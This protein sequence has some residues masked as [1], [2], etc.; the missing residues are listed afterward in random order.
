MRNASPSAIFLAMTLMLSS[1]VAAGDVGV[2][3]NAFAQ[4]QTAQLAGEMSRAAQLYELADSAAP[5]PEALRAALRARRASG[6]LDLA[7]T[8]AEALLERYPRDEQSAALA[9]E[10]LAESAPRLGRVVASCRPDP[11]QL[12]LGAAA[13]STQARARHVLFVAPGRHAFKA[14]FDTGTTGDKV[15]QAGAGSSSELEFAAPK[16]EAKSQPARATRGPAAS[17]PLPTAKQAGL[18]PAW[19]FAAGGVTLAL[20]ALTIWSGADTLEE[21]D[22][23]ERNPTLEGY[24]DGQALERRTNLLLVATS[25]GALATTS[26]GVFFTDWKGGSVERTAAGGRFRRV[27]IVPDLR[28]ARATAEWSF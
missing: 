28:G 2:A 27:A 1:S 14:A 11:C 22:A 4:A 8:H 24:N 26:L 17:P 18:A 5:S 25:I 15:V 16:P 21:H 12:L 6:R 19:F 10:T 13:V 9:R 3:A 23:Y 7:A 20:G